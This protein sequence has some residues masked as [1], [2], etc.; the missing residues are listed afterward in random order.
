MKRIYAD[1]KINVSDIKNIGEKFIIKFY[2]TAKSVAIVKTD[3]DIITED[4]K[5]VIKLN[6]SE[7][8][9]IGRGVLQYELN[10][11]TEDADYDDGSYDS[12]YT[13]TTEY[14]IMSNISIDEDDEDTPI[15]EVIA[16]MKNDINSL[17]SNKQDKL[18]AGKNITIE[19]NVISA[20]FDGED[21]DLSN[22]YDKTEIDNMEQVV[23][24]S[25]NDLNTRINAK[26]DASDVCSTEDFEEM[27]QVV[28]ASL[29][30]LNS[31]INAK[32]DASD[33]YSKSEIEEM[34]QVVAASLNDL[35]TRLG[36]K[37][38]TSDVY[39]KSEVDQAIDEAIA[40]GGAD[41]T[42]YYTK[43][44]SDAKYAT[45]TVVNEEIAARITAIREV[46]T[47]LAS[48]ADKSEMPTVPTN[49]SAFTNDAGYLT[50]HQSLSNYYDKTEIDNMV[51]DI[52]TL[53][54]NI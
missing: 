29:N 45:Q 30:D 42:N 49:V 19:N 44:E 14:Y 51:G 15:T 40:G 25:L 41:L 20:T 17:E 38:N 3:L 12:T 5:N 37:A 13:R 28:A 39:T 43:S 26:P 47:T 23:A 33:I 35:N 24:A 10:N 48:K 22:Y 21:I 32:P 34:E 36:A 6:W 52:E 9:T 2:T 53:L 46:N 18:T 11:I 4:D 16:D 8:A 27:E 7:L 50:Q 31:R 54:S 1:L